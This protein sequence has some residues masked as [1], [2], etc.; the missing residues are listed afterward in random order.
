MTELLSP[1][2]TFG[3]APVD[4]GL[5]PFDPPKNQMIL[6]MMVR[7]KG[8]DL[9]IPTELDWLK[10]VIEM[11]AYDND[12]F[13]YVTVRSGKVNTKTDDVWHVDGFSMRKPHPPEYNY[14]WTDRVATEFFVQDTKLPDDFD[15]M[16]HNIHWYFQ[17]MIGDA[18]PNFEAKEKHMYRIDPY[19]IHRR[20]PLTQGIQRTFFRVSVVPIEI[21]DDKNTQNPLLPYEPYGNMDIRDVLTRYPL[22]EK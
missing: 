14:I 18:G 15:P 16:K 5:V 20:P 17:D 7:R 3:T 10:E 21:E 19:V 4:I 8:G 11:A 22:E 6:R 9:H 12:W 2:N 1:K 13:I